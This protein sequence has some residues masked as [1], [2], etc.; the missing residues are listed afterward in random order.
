MPP[1][2]SNLKWRVTTPG[3]PVQIARLGSVQ[4]HLVETASLLQ[5]N[6]ADL[7]ASEIRFVPI[8]LAPPKA[9][10]GA[11]GADPASQVAPK[12]LTV[13]LQSALTV[14]GPLALLD[15]LVP[16]INADWSA[17]VLTPSTAVET[18]LS[19]DIEWTGALYAKP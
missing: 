19:L 9:T 15:A 18:A 5:A 7:A 2:A 8:K 10:T 17:M 14:K 3:Q 12:E 1:R 4:S 16:R 6:M 11:A 13:P